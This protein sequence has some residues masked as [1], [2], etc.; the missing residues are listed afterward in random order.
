MNR[1]SVLRVLGASAAAAGL[2]AALL[3]EADLL[4]AR[5]SAATLTD[6]NGQPHRLTGRL[7]PPRE[8]ARELAQ[9]GSR[10]D[11]R[12]LSRVVEQQG[13][14]LRADAAYAIE[15]IRDESESLGAIT[16]IPIEG[17]GRGGAYVRRRTPTSDEHALATWDA[18]RSNIEVF[19]ADGDAAVRR[20][21]VDVNADGS[22]VIHWWNGEDLMVPPRPTGRGRAGLAAPLA[23]GCI[24]QTICQWALTW[25]CRAAIVI[26]GV[27]VCFVV[28]DL[29]IGAGVVA[30]ALVFLFIE[31][32]TCDAVP[33][34]LCQSVCY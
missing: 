15:G 4:K 3:P 13:L 1:R 21:T 9:I 16:I 20:A 17:S 14:A 22:A 33:Q 25:I 29:T 31:G 6:V 34:W 28:L 23:D 8:L 7:L 19:L 18:A 5:A 26:V 27:V 10:N 24:V 12:V 30:C 2:Q 32:V 11:A